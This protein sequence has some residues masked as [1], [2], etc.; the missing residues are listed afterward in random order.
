MACTYAF[1][2]NCVIHAKFHGDGS[3]IMSLG[4]TLGGMQKLAS[5]SEST[6]RSEAI[7]CG[8]PTLQNGKDESRDVKSQV[9]ANMAKNDMSS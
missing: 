1:L 6:R 2:L 3:R 4:G 7:A 9:M 8:G 5:D